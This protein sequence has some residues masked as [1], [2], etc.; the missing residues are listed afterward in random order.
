MK[1]KYIKILHIIFWTVTL[2]STGLESVPSFG[3]EPINI[4]IE[5]YFIYAFSYVSIFYSFYF[6]ISIKYLKKEYAK[7]LTIF[8]LIFTVVYSVFFSF[9]YIAIIMKE[10]FALERNGFL[11][12]YSKYFLSFFETNFIFALS[13]SLIKIALL[14]YESTIKQKEIEKQLVIGELA[15]LKAQINPDF[16]VGTLIEFKNRI[17]QSPDDAILIIEKLSDIMSYMLYDTR[18]EFVE[19]SK[20]INILN[21]Y[22]FLYKTK[23]GS[24][25]IKFNISGTVTGKMIPPLILMTF[26]DVVF[27]LE[28]S[29][30]YIKEISVNLMV[31][32]N[33]VQL[34][35]EF[36]LK[37]NAG[38]KPPDKNVFEETFN[39]HLNLLFDKNYILEM[40]CN[41]EKYYF[42]LEIE[43]IPSVSGSHSEEK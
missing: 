9:I 16:L 26:S 12:E 43:N 31:N 21:N 5:D 19:L 27:N 35:I 10:I 6:F 3:K 14:W 20:E 17:E 42:A 15:L 23:L 36:R 37:E 29:Y 2:I 13:G 30:S 8:G 33:A 39:R 40:V 1:K 7:Y 18:K 34:N 22:F 28:V 32:D 4:I 25:G 24:V 38:P 41:D 11:L